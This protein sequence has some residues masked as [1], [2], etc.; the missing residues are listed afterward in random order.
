MNNLLRSIACLFLFVSLPSF[1]AYSFGYSGYYGGIRGYDTHAGG[2]THQISA[3]LDADKLQIFNDVIYGYSGSHNTIFGYDINT[4]Q[5]VLA[6]SLQKRP[7]SWD[8]GP[9]LTL[10]GFSGYYGQ[11]MTYDINTGA[12]IN[13]IS[14]AGMNA[15]VTDGNGAAFGYSGYY[16]GIRVYDTD[17]GGLTHQISA[18]LDGDKLQVYNDVIYGY[19]GSHNTIFGYDINT[20]QE[21]LAT[22][23]QK[24]PESWHI[25]PDLTLTGFSGYYGQIMTYDINTGAVI[26]EVPAAGMNALVTYSPVPL[27]AGIYLFVSGLI[28]LLMARRKS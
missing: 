22:S 2:L 4:G 11:I 15:L 13:E 8:I 27:P 23:L 14:A 24:R 19:S 1:G 28:G 10:T 26:N 20:G 21:V 7:E 18:S 17:A 6:T 9:D 25:G 16:G 12:V 5:E 3:S